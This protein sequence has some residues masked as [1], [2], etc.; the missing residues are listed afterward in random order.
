MKLLD[1]RLDLYCERAERAE[2]EGGREIPI[3]FDLPF[4][5]ERQVD[6]CDHLT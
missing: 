4:V 6:S 1:K 2:R 5:D 3:S